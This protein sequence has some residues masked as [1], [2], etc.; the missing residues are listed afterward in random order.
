M[1]RRSGMPMA[2]REGNR[3]GK[4]VRESRLS[5]TP[6]QLGGIVIYYPQTI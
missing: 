6:P 5:Q 4:I 2:S 1:S 3:A